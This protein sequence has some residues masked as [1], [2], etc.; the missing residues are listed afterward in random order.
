M[1]LRKQVCHNEIGNKGFTNDFIS[2]RVGIRS[3][4]ILLPILGITWIFGFLTF[5]SDT[6]AFKYIFAITNSLQ[7]RYFFILPKYGAFRFS[8]NTLVMR[9]SI[10]CLYNMLFME[11]HISPSFLLM[12]NFSFSGLPGNIISLYFKWRGKQRFAFLLF[13]TCRTLKYSLAQLVWIQKER[14]KKTSTS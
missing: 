1:C 7:V 8:R 13:Q 2:Y 5:N 10:P 6:I 3:S 12:L 9:N 11:I 4:V 14:K